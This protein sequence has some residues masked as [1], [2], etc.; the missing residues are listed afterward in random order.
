VKTVEVW[1]YQTSEP[2][3]HNAKNTYTKGELFCVYC[4]DERVFKY[5]IVHIFRIVEEYGSHPGKITRDPDTGG[6]KRVKDMNNTSITAR[7][8]GWQRNCGVSI[9]LIVCAILALISLQE[10][11]SKIVL[12]QI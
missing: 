11:Q 10:C 3:I 1:L 6:K 8:C 5:P 7:R 12:S 9:K 2:L 4:A